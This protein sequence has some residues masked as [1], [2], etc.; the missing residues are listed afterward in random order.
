[1][2]RYDAVMESLVDHHQSANNVLLC[3]FKLHGIVPIKTTRLMQN[4]KLAVAVSKCQTLPP[5]VQT[6]RPFW[7][8]AFQLIGKLY[9]YDH[10]KEREREREKTEKL[11][12]N[13]IDIDSFQN[14]TIAHE[15]GHAIGF[16]H[17]QS[18]PD[19]DSHVLIQR[20]QISRGKLYN[21]KKRTWGEI[22]TL[23]IPYDLGSD[24]HYGATVFR[25]TKSLPLSVI[26]NV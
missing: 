7:H 25:Q 20:G 2:A 9:R 14:G 13:C 4:S 15:V 19:R 8:P 12:V 11:G 21:F 6:F 3:S 1:M 10:L 26:L 22:L 18:R 16:W 23:D 5:Y 17:E 24:M